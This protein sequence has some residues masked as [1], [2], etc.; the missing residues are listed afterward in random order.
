MLEYTDINDAA[1]LAENTIDPIA[2][3]YHDAFGVPM[4]HTLRPYKTSL[5]A[6]SKAN[7][8]TYVGGLTATFDLDGGLTLVSKTQYR[9]QDA[10]IRADL[11]G[12]TVQYWQVEYDE[13]E[14]TFTQEFNLSRAGDGSLDWVAGLFYYHDVGQLRNNAYNDFFNTGTRTSWL[15]S[16]VGVT[17]ES[18]AAFADGTYH[19]T[20]NLWLT[21]GLRFTSEEK[22]VDSVGLLAPFAEFEDSHRWDKLTPRIAAR[23]ALSPNANLYGSVGQ[24]FMSGNYSYTTVGPQEP[25][26]PET[27]TQYEFGYKFARGGWSFD[28]AA[29]YSDYNDLQV[30]RFADDCGCYRLDSAPKAEIYGA[31]A[32]LTAT[33]SDEL[34]VNAGLAYTHARYKQ[35]NGSG[36]TGNPVIPPNYGLEAVPTDFDGGE[37]IRTPEWAGNLGINYAVPT[38]SGRWELSGNYFYSSRVPLSPGGQLSQDPYGL[39][40]LRG[41][42]TAPG[43]KWLVAVYGNNVTDEQY[44]VF[45]AGGFLGNNYILGQPASWGAQLEFRF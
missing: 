23:Y 31:E 34:S 37:M 24:G 22:T 6:Q 11:D 32:R 21:A 12:T 13:T 4:V 14:E 10:E 43:G 29:F 9:D 15:Y 44:N 40:S 17:T 7:P 16:D 18:I 26:D 33:I 35:Y 1:G 42:W 5:N 2:A 38:A 8:V 28:T 30:F 19:A 20:E 3:F 45:S 25:V 27:V 39:L 36:L 41:G